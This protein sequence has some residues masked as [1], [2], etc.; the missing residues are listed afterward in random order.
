MLRR[1]LRCKLAATAAA[2]LL[3]L[4]TTT[5]AAP[6]YR[7][8]IDAALA[9]AASSAPVALMAYGADTAANTAS[10]A[11]DAAAN[12]GYDAFWQALPTW[13]TP[14]V[15]LDIPGVL[16][17]FDNLFGWTFW[18]YGF[19]FSIGNDGPLGIQEWAPSNPFVD[20][21]AESMGTTQGEWPGVGSLV[22]LLT[23]MGG[24]TNIESYANWYDPTGTTCLICDTF[25]LLGPLDTPL[26]SWTSDIPIPGQ[27]LPEFGLSILGTPIFGANLGDAF[28]YSPLANNFDPPAVLAGAA[29][30]P[31]SLVGEL[32]G[33]MGS[34]VGAD[35]SALL[36]S[37]GTEIGDVV[38]FLGGPVG[39]G[40]DLALLL[41]GLAGNPAD[42]TLLAGNVGA[43]LAASLL[44][45]LSADLGT[46]L[47]TLLAS[48]IP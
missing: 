2:A 17:G 24:F 29:G 26:F 41:G 39:A 27:G 31:A 14:T 16:N 4:A 45:T 47:P 23:P 32:G 30:A 5:V 22:G 12:T 34:N 9:P 33:P 44:S 42:L 6:A 28:D 1:A 46:L 15:G 25:H 13:P 21:V 37:V 38:N 35:L 11:A 48:L 18:N 3:A 43:D 40:A 36:P 8:P 7:A 19:G 10:T 20:V